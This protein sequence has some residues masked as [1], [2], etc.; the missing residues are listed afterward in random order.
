VPGLKVAHR[1]DADSRSRAKSL[2]RAERG[3]AAADLKCINVEAILEFA[4]KA[5][6]RPKQLWLG[7]SLEQKQRLQSV[8]FLDGLTYTGDG[9]GTAVSNSFFNVFQEFAAE[10]VSLGSLSSQ[11]RIGVKEWPHIANLTTPQQ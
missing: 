11:I 10:K 1:L 7:S 8:S 4:E 5:A 9:F 6:E 3:F 2:S